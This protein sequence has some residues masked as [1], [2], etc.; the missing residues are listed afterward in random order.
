MGLDDKKLSQRQRDKATIELL[1]KLREQLLKGDISDAR[2]AA[3]NLSWKQEDGLEVSEDGE[4]G[5]GVR[6]EEYEGQDAEA[7]VGSSGEGVETSRP[8]YQGC[9][10]QVSVF[11]KGRSGEKVRRR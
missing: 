9:V 2:Q 5:S 3:F 11:D 4:K 8:H 6:A 1:R 10:Y 7:G